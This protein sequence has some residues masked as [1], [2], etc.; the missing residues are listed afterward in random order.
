M[1]DSYEIIEEL[2]RLIDENNA[3]I[4]PIDFLIVIKDF[5]QQGI[6][7]TEVRRHLK[8]IGFY[9]D[10]YGMLKKIVG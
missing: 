6:S 4:S 1:I 9:I 8:K 2:E 5:E 10:D 7:E 3:L